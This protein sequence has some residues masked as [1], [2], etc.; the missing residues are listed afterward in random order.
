MFDSN[1]SNASDSLSQFVDPTSA[2]LSNNGEISNLFASQSGISRAIADAKTSLQAI[3]TSTDLMTKLEIAFGTEFDRGIANSLFQHFASGDFSD[4]PTVEILPDRVLPTANSA[5]AAATDRVYLSDRFVAENVAKPDAITGVLLEEYGHAI[6]S[7]INRV[8]SLGDEGEI[9]SA[10]AQGGKLDESELRKLKA[11]DDTATIVVGGQTIAIEQAVFAG[12]PFANYYSGSADPDTI[13][14]NGGDDT[15]LGNGG[16]DSILGGSGNDLLDGG[17]GQNTLDGGSGIDT[18]SYASSTQNLI[19]A[20]DGGGGAAGIANNPGN[21]IY[22]RLTN[23]E[24]LVGG[25]GND[26]LLGSSTDN[27]INGGS[28][29]DFLN[30]FSGSDRLL[31]GEGDDTL[32]DQVGNDTLD[33]GN[34]NDSL[35]GGSLG[36]SLLIGGSGNDS[37]RYQ[38]GSGNN[39]TLDGGSGNDSLIGDMSNDMLNGGSGNDTLDGGTGGNDTLDGFG[40]SNFE[41][42]TLRWTPK[43]GQGVKL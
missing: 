31:G 5:F 19:A 13:A 6:D 3:A 41:Q 14:G 25:S 21:G 2:G 9:F 26:T 15:L 22:D 29:N 32:N 38:G 1:L 40:F 27:E 39:G 17:L 43:T 35:V 28:G 23:V 16:N 42:D 10:I 37:L 20:L 34:G 11:K 18:A 24:N 7:L 12:D 36:N 8:D 4:L 30:G 33:G